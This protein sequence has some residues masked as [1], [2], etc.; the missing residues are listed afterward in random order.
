MSARSAFAPGVRA[1]FTWAYLAV[2]LPVAVATPYLQVLLQIRGFD[3]Q[4]I[5][6]IQGM[7]EVMAVLAPPVW[8]WL[9]DRFGRP[10]TFLALGAVASAPAFWLFGIVPTAMTAMAAAVLFGFCCRPQV[11]LADGI[12][13]RHIGH[14]GG[15]YGVVRIGGSISF[16]AVTLL[17]E[18]LGVARSQT[19]GLILV[20]FGVACALLA[21]STALLPAP[22]AGT[23]ASHAHW[24]QGWPEARKAFLSRPFIVFTLCAFLSRLAMTAYYGFFSLYLREVHHFP[25]AG[26]IWMIG[27]LSE[28]PMIYFSRR[29]MDRIGVRNLMALGLLGCVVRLAGFAVAPG[30]MAVIALQF[31]HALTFGAYHTASVTQVAR[32]V[33]AHLQGTAQTVFAALTT[34]A[35]GLLG[36]VLGGAVCERFGF[37][38]LY[39]SA[40]AV[41]LAG[42]LILLAA[43][44]SPDSRNVADV[45]R[46]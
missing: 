41:G 19:G 29:I 13:F 6:S 33:P 22:E 10:R 8:G 27:P 30:I 28:I 39:A 11:P 34:G 32:S 15:D 7:L 16:I 5:G 1:R 35:G 2:F 24:N 31:L 23:Q 20:A 9:S 36:G 14:S 45:A 43:M 40:A 12:A 25:Q 4:T 18:W 44:P 21:A 17:L 46:V 26:L 42:L 38:T 37:T 3:R